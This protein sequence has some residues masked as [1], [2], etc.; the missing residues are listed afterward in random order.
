VLHHLRPNGV[1]HPAALFSPPI[2]SFLHLK[3]LF[4]VAGAAFAFHT[5]VCD[6]FWPSSAGRSGTRWAKRYL[7]LYLALNAWLFL[8]FFV[9][10]F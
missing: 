6:P 3:Y 8:L 7:G 4:I 5:F 1:R 9:I 2:S 10:H